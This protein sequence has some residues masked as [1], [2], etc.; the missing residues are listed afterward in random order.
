[1]R[2]KHEYAEFL[3]QILEAEKNRMSRDE[4]LRLGDEAAVHL[5]S[6]GSGTPLMSEVLLDEVDRR[7]LKRL[8]APSYRTWLKSKCD[9][10][11]DN[12]SND[13]SAT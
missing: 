9:T 7:L 5:A 1:M 8:N 12:E 4:L 3:L 10:K 13:L 6:T 11:S 2:G